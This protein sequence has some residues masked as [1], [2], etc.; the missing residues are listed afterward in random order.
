MQC[1]EN[2][3]YWR[4]QAIQCTLKSNYCSSEAALFGSLF[5]F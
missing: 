1:V 5:V 3:F 4:V 2:A